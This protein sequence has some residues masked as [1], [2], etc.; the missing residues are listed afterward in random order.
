MTQLTDKLLKDLVGLKQRITDNRDNVPREIFLFLPTQLVK[1]PPGLE[2]LNVASTVRKA[3]IGAK[4]TVQKAKD[5]ASNGYT[6]LE[7]IIKI[8][9]GTDLDKLKEIFESLA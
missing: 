7:I 9:K 5:M 3:N 6:G 4:V 2:V 8:D 1:K